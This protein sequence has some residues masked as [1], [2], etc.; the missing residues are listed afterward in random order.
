MIKSTNSVLLRIQAHASFHCASFHICMSTLI[1][2][3]KWVWLIKN[4]PNTSLESGNKDGY[5]DASCYF[6]TIV[7]LTVIFLLYSTRFVLTS[8]SQAWLKK[9]VKAFFFQ[10]SY[11][12]ER[13]TL[14][15]DSRWSKE[16][17]H[18]FGTYCNANQFL[19][20]YIYF[21]FKN[22]FLRQP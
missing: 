3:E 1:S 6:C 11:Y 20:I 17:W 13:T 14:D 10:A 19:N 2:I 5:R 8:N 9:A 21:F 18:T 7:D 16:K 4:E 22:I 12:P 15:K